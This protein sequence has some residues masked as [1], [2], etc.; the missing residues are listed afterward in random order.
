MNELLTK[1]E[2]FLASEPSMVWTSGGAAIIAAIQADPYLVSDVKNWL[3]L[4]ITLGI[5]LIIRS[6]VSPAKGS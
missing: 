1:L 2:A 6:N 3:T 4:G 5:G